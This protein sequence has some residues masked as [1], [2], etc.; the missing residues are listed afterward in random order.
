MKL[1]ELKDLKQYP[2]S[3]KD[4]DHIAVCYEPDD[5]LQTEI[6]QVLRVEF[7]LRKE[8]QDKQRA[9]DQVN[10][11]KKRGGDNSCVVINLSD[12]LPE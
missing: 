10:S 3:L 4:G 1:S 2:I 6:D 9:L 7:E 12:D 5:D 8:E 11:L